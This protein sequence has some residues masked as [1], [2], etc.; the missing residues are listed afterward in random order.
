M[1]RCRDLEQAGGLTDMPEPQLWRPHR[2]PRVLVKVG[3]S[4]PS[5]ALGVELQRQGPAPAL[6]GPPPSLV[7]GERVRRYRTR[8]G[9]HNDDTV[10]QGQRRSTR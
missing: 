5:W 8:R 9:R 1:C 2:G 3:I 6:R 10:K 7:K 4:P